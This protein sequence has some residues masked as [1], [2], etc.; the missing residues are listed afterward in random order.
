MV[1]AFEVLIATNPVRNLIREGRSNQL[2]NIMTTNQKEGMRTL[3]T[4]LA[5]LI[6]AG[7]HH[8]RGCPRRL[9]S[10]QGT[11]PRLSRATTGG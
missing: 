2:L 1:A 6:V 11:G 5:E 7:H 9:R 3:E 10:P 8:L 4:S